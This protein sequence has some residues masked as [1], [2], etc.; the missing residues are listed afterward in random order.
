VPT[1]ICSSV[2][3]FGYGIT[4]DATNVYIT[5]NVS[6]TGGYVEKCPQ[7]GVNLVATQIFSFPGSGIDFSR[8]HYD[9]QSNL[10]YFGDNNSGNTW[11]ITPGGATQWNVSAN[12]YGLDTDANNLYM[13]TGAGLLSTNKFSGGAVVTINNATPYQRGVAFDP[14]LN[15]V[16]AAAINS[17]LVQQCPTVPGGC[18]TWTE[19]NVGPFDIHVVGPNVFFLGGSGGGLYRCASNND[20]SPANAIQFSTWTGQGFALDAA[21]VYFT[22]YNFNFY[23]CPVTGCPGGVPV[24]IA[25]LGAGYGGAQTMAVDSTYLYWVTNQGKV[26]RV[27][28]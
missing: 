28:K 19:P 26:F 15:R 16:W 1:L 3:N 24:Q 18:V 5:E 17:N 23:S 4:L 14:I 10:V 12:A 9:P 11:A 2:H 27:A 13:G 7:V 8:I 6:T 25:A 22:D 21:N 20:C